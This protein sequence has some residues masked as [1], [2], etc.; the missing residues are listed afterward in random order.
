MLENL[1]NYAVFLV[2]ILK[3]HV[4]MTSI[5]D[6]LV[7]YFRYIRLTFTALKSVLYHIN[8]LIQHKIAPDMFKI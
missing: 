6:I 8:I 7:L 1:A 4:V 5:Y 3:L 2:I